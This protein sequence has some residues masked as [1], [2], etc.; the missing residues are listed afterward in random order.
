METVA[1]FM[2][3]PADDETV[4]VSAHDDDVT[5]AVGVVGVEEEPQAEEKAR[6]TSPSSVRVRMRAG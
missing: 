2:P 5:G 1:P 6:T 4:P 3:P